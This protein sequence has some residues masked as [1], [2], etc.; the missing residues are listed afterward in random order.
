MTVPSSGDQTLNFWASFDIEQDWDFFF[1]EVDP[2]GSNEWT[3]LPD[4]NGHTTQA[5][6]ESCHDGTGWGADLHARLL[7]YQTKSR[8]TCSPTGTTGEWNAATGSSGGWQNWSVDLSAYAG[9]E[10]EVALVHASDW[11]V[12]NLGVWVDDISLFGGPVFSFEGTDLGGWSIGSLEGSPNQA[13]WQAAPSTQTFQE[14]AVIGTKDVTFVDGRQYLT[15][16]TRDTVYAGFELGT[17]TPA[18]RA[19]FLGETLEYFGLK[20]END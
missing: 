17:L 6:G 1:V 14:G 16:A 9:Q 2:A 20:P 13:T 15:S 8:D 10:V 11:A 19:S 7:Q 12:Q 4:A 5:T 18:E 3:T